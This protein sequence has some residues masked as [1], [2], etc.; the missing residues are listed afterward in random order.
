MHKAVS[1]FLASFFLV[2]C[3]AISTTTN[4]SGSIPEIGRAD[5]KV[6]LA[7]GDY[8]PDQQLI[9]T[10]SISLR[11]DDVAKTADEITRY[12][13][14]IKGRIDSKNEYRN[15]ESNQLTSVD[16]MLKVPKVQLDSALT[17]LQTFGNVEGFSKS[18]VDVTM[19]V[20]DLDARIESLESSIASLKQLFDQ[21]KNVTDLLAAES[22]L[23]ARQAELDSLKSQRTY[24]ADQVDLAA[25]WISIYPKRSLDAVAPIGFVAGLETGW[26][27]VVNFA[28]N[29]TTWAGL[30]LPWLGLVLA[31]ILILKILTTLLRPS[32]KN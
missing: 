20:I 8:A 32:K 3:G 27:A 22:A 31:L 17:R 15:P 21:A 16:L 6:G 28:S 19:Q 4:D 5:A 18:S 10:A 30:A 23:T 11:A 1:I 29:L 26:E 25:I 2:G 12:V 7:V 9:Q 13:S 24:L 14:S